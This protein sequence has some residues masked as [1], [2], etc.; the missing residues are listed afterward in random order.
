MNPLSTLPRRSWLERLSL[1]LAIALI[2]L[3]AGTLAGWWLQMPELIQPFRGQAPLKING[4]IGFAVLGIVLLALELGKRRVAWLGAG[5][6]LLALL[7][8]AQDAFRQN[9]GLDE[10]LGRD[11]VLVNT[12]HAGR[13]STM[14]A[15][16]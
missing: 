9:F 4:A 12:E 13:I 15:A 3:G 14:V 6:A 8:L 2:V 1:G 7:T 5:V 10:L 16:G 11:H